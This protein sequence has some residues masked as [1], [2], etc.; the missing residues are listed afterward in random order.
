MYMEHFLESFE[1]TPT[2]GDSSGNTR[3]LL[4]ASQLSTT[5]HFSTRIVLQ[6]LERT[7]EEQCESDATLQ[8]LSPGTHGV[9]LQVK[10]VYP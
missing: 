5:L 7:T 4:M 3:Y 6:L 1:T 9:L 10:S 2:C 8:I